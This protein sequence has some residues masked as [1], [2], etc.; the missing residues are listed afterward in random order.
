[1]VVAEISTTKTTVKPK[2]TENVQPIAL[3]K[4]SEPDAYV[5]HDFGDPG[6]MSGDVG[7]AAVDG[8]PCPA[9]HIRSAQKSGK[10]E[11]IARCIKL[12]DE[13]VIRRKRR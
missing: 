5:A 10:E 2:T 13:G 7:G 11:P 12:G 4:V 6:M 1:M 8:D 9:V 3:I